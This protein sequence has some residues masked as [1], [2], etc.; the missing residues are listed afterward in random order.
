[1]SGHRLSRTDCRTKD[2]VRVGI[3]DAIVTLCRCLPRGGLTTCAVDEALRDIAGDEDFAYLLFIV[4]AAGDVPE[5][6]AQALLDAIRSG[7]AKRECAACFDRDPYECE[8]GRVISRT[9]MTPEFPVE[10]C[11]C[12]CHPREEGSA[13]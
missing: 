3:L 8:I 9:G 6:K 1:M 4:A 7:V 10:P 5:W 13:S 11:L 12:A 2:G